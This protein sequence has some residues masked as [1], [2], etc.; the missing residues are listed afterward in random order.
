LTSLVERL[1]DTPVLL[2]AT[3]RPGYQPPWLGHTAVAQIALPRLSLHES[4]AMLQSVPQAAQLPALVHQAIV[5]RAAGNPFFVEELTWAVVEQGAHTDTVPLPETIEAVLAARLDRL[6]AEAKR[7]VQIAAVIGTEV[8]APLLQRLAGLPEETVQRGLAHLQGTELLYETQLYPEPVYTFKHALTHEVAYG[9]LLQERRRVL[10]AQIVDAIEVLDANCLGEQVERLAY[11]A[12]RGEVWDKALAYSRQA[13]EKAMAQSAHREAVRYFEQALRALAPLPETR[14]RCEQ[15]I[16]LRFALRN[17]LHPSGNSER[18]LA[19][20][21]EA[22]ALAAALD[23]PRRLAQVL[24]FLSLHFSF[25]GVYDQALGF[26]QRAL[27]LAMTSGEVVL[28]ALANLYL[29]NIYHQQGHYDRAIDCYRQTIASFEG[30]RRHE[31]FGHAL[32]PAVNACAQLAKCYAELG[33]FAEGRAFGDEGLQIAETAEH[34]ISLLF[35]SWGGGLLSLRQ[36]D[37]H[38]ALPL[39]ERAMRLCQDA[40]LSRWYPMTA[41]P[42]G[43]AY[44]LA[45]RVPDAVLLLTQVMEQ[46]TIAEMGDYHAALCCLAL[47]EAQMLAGCLEE[48]HAL[49]GR[50]LQLSRTC[51]Q[52]GDEAYA[53]RLLGD[54]AAHREPPHVE[55]V[56]VHYRQALALAKELGMRP[57]QAH[58]HRGLG[59]LYATT[60]QW[61]PARA[62]LAAAIEMYRAMEM[63][64]WLPQ[65]EAALAQVEGR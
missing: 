21:R 22:E 3:Y 54:I 26:A 64:F 63:T 16:D 39:L 9:S 45:G 61:E 10:H 50:A 48:A 4:L 30:A 46:V 24:L 28:H 38:R 29:G 55:E 23:D 65:A 62:E 40:S 17:A 43:A 5:A 2:L 6:P 41:A 47:G 42:L 51:K 15:A 49:A 34:P 32:I 57:L 7:L 20:L 19:S 8:P 44:V 1:G 53:L 12:L 56:G 37:L 13:G 31:H 58:C 11:H 36:G 27:V 35:A 59:T 14:A 60:G 25:R 18:I 33:L 52:R